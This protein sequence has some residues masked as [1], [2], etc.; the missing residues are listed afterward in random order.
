[1]AKASSR[2]VNSL[3]GKMEECVRRESDESGEEVSEVN[4]DECDIDSE[5]EAMFL[6]EDIILDGQSSDV[7]SDVERKPDTSS[8][9]NKRPRRAE[10]RDRTSSG[11]KSRP[12]TPP[13]GSA[14]RRRTRSKGKAR[15]KRKGG[16][17][18]GERWNDVDVPDVTPQQPTFRPAN[19]PGPQLIRTA[20][21][22]AMELFQLF[23]S[24]SVLHRII[25]NTNDFGSSRGSTLASP[26]T[27]LTLEEMFSFMSVLIYM[28]I[29]K[30]SSFTDYW[31]GGKLYSLPFPKQVMTGKRFL[32]IC[33]TF[34]LSSVADDAA[35]EE[36]R[37]TA[38]FDRLCKIKPL[39][40]EIRDAC[41]TNYHPG[42]DISIDERMVASKAR[43]GIKQ[44]M[45][46][47]PVRWGYKLFVLADSRNGYTWDFF[48]YE[49][50]PK[51]DSGKGFAYDV[52]MELIDT[53]S[54]G[55][56]YKLFV[57]AFYTSP[58]LFRD[59]L[60]KKIW[61]CGTVRATSSGFPKGKD[62][63][64]D[65]KS[66]RGAIRWI[67]KD[68]LLFLQWRDARD[69]S[70]CSTLH[71]AHGKDTV[72]RRAKGPD[73]RW[74]VKDIPIPPVVKEYNQCTGGVDLS[75]AL[76]GYYR[77]LHKTQKWY[78]T[79]FYHFMDIAIVNAFILHKELAK[80]KGEV[81]MHQK[82][83]RE[84]L[85]EE[86]AEFGCRPTGRPVCPVPSRAHHRPVHISGDSTAGRLKCRHCHAKTPVKCS[87]CEVPL[88]FVPSRDCYNDW[89]AAKN[90]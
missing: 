19:S 33:Q 3:Q 83:F 57:D 69:V 86:L 12:R 55:S 73:G 26:W 71:A 59:L 67:R 31:R 63:G 37:G 40:Q 46:N 48:I 49:G 24:T 36:K 64:L 42:Q 68:S 76:M 89:H 25:Q 79:F 82:A 51:A 65:S 30:C 10:Q 2:T 47:K 54:L 58:T 87:S 74:A 5:A 85:A 35:N 34:H 90:L 39:Y 81:P 28:G 6:E 56:G 84:T 50:K 17:T 14:G 88:C 80:G 22:T 43:I 66:P 29:V 72:Q 32:T 44:Y 15:E 62:N 45:K 7:D 38:A 21:Y 9:L 52:V 20:M 8:P 75:D 61:S 27:D 23:F 53:R 60:R 41:K 78:K 4:S 16:G 11:D 77:I 70:L 13:R 1:M 18:S